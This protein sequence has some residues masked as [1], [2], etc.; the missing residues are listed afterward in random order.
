MKI[1]VKIK[2][3]MIAVICFLITCVK[4]IDLSKIDE[5]KSAFI[6][7]SAILNKNFLNV[8]EFTQ[9]FNI[10]LETDATVNNLNT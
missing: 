6:S 3:K 8:D 4:S 1:R 2:K 7:L 10:F 5:L 9:S